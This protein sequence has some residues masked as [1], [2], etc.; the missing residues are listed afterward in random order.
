[1]HGTKIQ[2]QPKGIRQGVSAKRQVRIVDEAEI[3][4]LQ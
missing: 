1:M 3:R 4:K 2:K